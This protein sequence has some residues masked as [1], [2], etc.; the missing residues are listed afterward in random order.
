ML[1]PPARLLFSRSRL[2]RDG[3]IVGCCFERCAGGQYAP[4]LVTDD[5]H[6]GVVEAE[7]AFTLRKPPVRHG[8]EGVVRGVRVVLDGQRDE[9]TRPGL[10][11]P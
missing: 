9:L 5:L 2:R 7:F 10:V 11:P 4:R 3:D 6:C 8:D 1:Q